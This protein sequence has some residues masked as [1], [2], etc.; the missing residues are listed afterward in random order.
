LVLEFAVQHQKG[1][2]ARRKFSADLLAIG[3][4]LGVG[5]RLRH[6]ERCPYREFRILEVFGADQTVLERR[7]NIG[8]VRGRAG[9]ARETISAVVRR[10]DRAGFLAELHESSIEQRKTRLIEGVELLE[11]QQSNR[12]AEIE[13]R[14]ADWAEQI[15][16]IEFGNPCANARE[17]G[18][19]NDNRGLQRAAQAREIHAGVNMRGVRD[20]DEH[21]VRGVLRPAGEIR[22]TKIGRVELGPSDLG[23][24]V[25]A[26]RPRCSGV[27]G[28]SSGKRLARREF[29]FLS[30]SQTRQAERDATRGSPF[31]ELSPRSPHRSTS[32]I[33]CHNNGKPA[34]A[35]KA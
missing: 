10:P 9:H 26:A 33:A 8:R 32:G 11:D 1:R 21:G 3:R 5:L 25:D 16:G 15:A 34:T 14:R 7:V 19:G 30:Q 27:P 24:A 17:I 6:R 4:G 23:D 20:Q 2:V 28:L 22:G 12:L 31:H 13:R 35:M 29:R 18:G